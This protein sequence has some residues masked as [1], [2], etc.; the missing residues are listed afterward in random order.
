MGLFIEGLMLK[1]KKKKALYTWL[2]FKQ[3]AG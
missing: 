1:Q 3:D 2:T